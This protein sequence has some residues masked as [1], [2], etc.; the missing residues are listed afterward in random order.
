LYASEVAEIVMFV[1][2]AVAFAFI[3][4][5]VAVAWPWIYVIFLS[6]WD[7]AT[8][9]DDLISF[10]VCSLCLVFPC[11]LVTWVWIRDSSLLVE[12]CTLM[13]YRFMQLAYD[14]CNFKSIACFRALP[15]LA[16]SFQKAVE[17]KSPTTFLTTEST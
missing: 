12:S 13:I 7:Y 10:A 5:A 3:I 14:S 4:L 11:W 6:A 8:V 9:I 17:L 2:V 15:E 1:E 16:L